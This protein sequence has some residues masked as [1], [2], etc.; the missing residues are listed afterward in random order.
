MIGALFAV[1]NG[2]GVGVGGIVA[3]QLYE[4]FGPRKTFAVAT[5]WAA[6]AYCIFCASMVIDNLPSGRIDDEVKAL[7]KSSTPDNF[8]EFNE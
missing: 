8:E 6:L 3:G 4:H 2:L 5:A 1:Y 7:E